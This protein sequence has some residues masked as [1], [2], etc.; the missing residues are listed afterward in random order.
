MLQLYYGLVNPFL[1]YGITTW[2]SI[3]PTYIKKLKSLR[4]GAIR[5]VARCHY[6]DKVN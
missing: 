1:S 2:G 3:Y 5:A 6:R 4:N